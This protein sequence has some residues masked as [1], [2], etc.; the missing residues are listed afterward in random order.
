MAISLLS[1]GSEI[2]LVQFHEPKGDRVGARPGERLPQ[3]AF[4][5][6]VAESP[7]VDFDGAT[8][9]LL[10][11]GLVEKEGEEFILTQQG[12]DYLYTNAGHRVGE[13]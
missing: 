5:E 10:E 7:G 9:A 13:G 8:Q 1:K 6:A 12:Y 11:G 4:E 2:L 3:S